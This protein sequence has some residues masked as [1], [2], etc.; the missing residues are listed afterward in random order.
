MYFFCKLTVSEV[1]VEF[2][3]KIEYIEL[4]QKKNR[5][6]DRDLK[7]LTGGGL[8]LISKWGQRIKGDTKEIEGLYMCV[9]VSWHSTK[10]K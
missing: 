3:W 10:H 7:I 2:E 5:E 6:G 4:T 8:G 9:C 1:L